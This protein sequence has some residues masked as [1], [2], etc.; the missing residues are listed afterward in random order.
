MNKLSRRILPSTGALSAFDA[1]ARLGN[2]TDAARELSLTQ[3]AVSH[4]IN[5]LEQLLGVRLLDRNTRRTELT[6][7]G[8]R[9]A[10]SI[11]RALT[12]IRE[13]S[14]SIIINSNERDLNLAVLPTFGTRWLIPRLPR[15]IERHPDINLNFVTRIGQVDFKS[16]A[17]DAAIH[18][19]QPNW[20]DADFLKLMPEEVIP[21]GSPST[22]GARLPVSALDISE[23]TLLHMASRPDAWA[24]WFTMQDTSPPS[25]AGVKFEQFGMLI[26]ACCA[27]I[28][29]ALL[30]KLLIEPELDSGQLVA[31]VDDASKSGSAYYFATPSF[32]RLKPSTTALRNWLVEEIE[33]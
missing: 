13:A 6:D 8:Q 14:L 15:F 9:Y 21:V 2:F 4:Q 24:H 25:D 7:A 10:V 30:P 22:V 29:V 16:E 31:L 19:G 20:P 28:G 17:I 32:G 27:G 33:A 26:Q 23:M 3:G 11:M 1:V 12:E 5:N 18:A